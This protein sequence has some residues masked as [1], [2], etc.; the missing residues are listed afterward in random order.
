MK[1]VNFEGCEWP[2]YWACHLMSSLIA[3]F[4]IKH[5]WKHNKSEKPATWAPVLRPQT[6]KTLFG[7]VTFS[8]FFLELYTN[9][10]IN[11]RI[12]FRP[13]ISKFHFKD[14]V[15][16]NLL[17]FWFPLFQRSNSSWILWMI[18]SNYMYAIQRQDK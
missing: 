15:S 17:V 7:P 14:W 6:S 10:Q 16:D 13:V 11:S 5:L 3:G 18:M 9:V 4:L 2:L 12:W 1:S 8:V